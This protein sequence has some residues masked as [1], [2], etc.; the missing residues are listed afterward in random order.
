MVRVKT[1]VDGAKFF[2]EHF[3]SLAKIEEL[4]KIV[5]KNGLEGQRLSKIYAPVDTG[6][7]KR[8]IRLYRSTDRFRVSWKSEAEYALIQEMLYT[9]HIRP[10]YYKVEG[11]FI[12]EVGAF[13]DGK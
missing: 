12:R 11:K 8:S 13:I 10:A 4:Q 5:L 1:S 7:L 9:P 3:K 6:F 2:A